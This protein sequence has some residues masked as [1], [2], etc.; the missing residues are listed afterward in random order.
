MA[1]KKDTSEGPPAASRVGVHGASVLPRVEVDGYNLELKDANGFLG[2]RASKK[3][4]Y[5]LLDK[6]RKPLAKQGKDP[7]GDRPS[8]EIG[9]KELD[10]ALAKGDSAEAG[11]VHAVIEDF[12]QELA[13]ILRRFLREKSWQKTPRI[14]IGGGMRDHRI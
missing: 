13:F 11:L 3:A 14:A 1:K 9:K 5:A 7:F 6:W 2:D 12:A 8:S 4:L 10:A